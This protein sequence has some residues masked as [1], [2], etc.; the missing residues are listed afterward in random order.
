MLKVLAAGQPEG[1]A[2]RL[3]SRGYRVRAQ[4][5]GNG[6][7]EIEVIGAGA[8]DVVDLRE[9]E[10]PEPMRR[11]LLAAAALKEGG[12]FLARLPHVPHPL[13]PL[14]D[15]RKLRWWV[16]E[17]ADHSALLAVRPAD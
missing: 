8:P 16:H 4:A 2:G 7:W 17:E 14:L 11:V 10:A 12:I 1:L 13:F 5:C 9:L 15:E 3:E 6:S